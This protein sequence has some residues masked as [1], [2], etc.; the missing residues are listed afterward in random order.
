MGIL[1]FDGKKYE[2]DW[3]RVFILFIGAPIFALGLYFSH[4]WIWLH[5]ISAKITVWLINLFT[6]GPKS[7]V[8]FNDNFS[9]IEPWYIQIVTKSGTNL[10]PIN[11]ETLCTGIHAIAMFAGVILFTPHSKDNNTSKDIWKRKTLALLSTTIVFYIVNILR[12]ILQLILYRNGANWFDVHYPI[13]AASSFIAIACVLLMHKFI[14]EFIMT[15]IWIG[16]EIKLRISR[17]KNNKNNL[18]EDNSE[19]I[20]AQKP[21]IEQNLQ[22]I[23]K[24]DENSKINN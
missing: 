17:G 2:F 8:F 16:D 10:G 11:F 19:I 15:L 3:P 9:P 22:D 21:E 7:Y 6:T 23:K 20:V 14:P 4:N 18:S 24:T 13:S 1:E 5:E 12:M